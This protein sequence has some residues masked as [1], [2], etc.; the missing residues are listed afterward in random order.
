M[1]CEKKKTQK[2]RE[3]KIEKKFVQGK[4]SKNIRVRA[5]KK[6]KKKKSL[7]QSGTEKKFHARRK[8]EGRRRLYTGYQLQDNSG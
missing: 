2:I 1:W 6:K 5:K 3:K 4:N 7:H 8:G